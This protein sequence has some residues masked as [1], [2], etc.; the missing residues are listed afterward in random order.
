MSEP[1]PGETT[2]TVRQFGVDYYGELKLDE[3]ENV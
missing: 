2:S 3:G 1:Q